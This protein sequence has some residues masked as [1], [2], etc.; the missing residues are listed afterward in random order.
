M[1]TLLVPTMVGWLAVNLACGRGSW[2]DELLGKIPAGIALGLGLTSATTFLG[3]LVLGRVTIVFELILLG[4]LLVAT[5]RFP[6]EPLAPPP[7]RRPTPRWMIAWVAAALVLV[8]SAG[9]AVWVSRAMHEPNGA[10]DAWDFWNMRGRWFV[11]AGEDWSRAFS[12]VALGSHPS[13]PPL[14]SASLARGFYLV[15]SETVAVPMLH[16]AVFTLAPPLVIGWTVLRVRGPLQACLA[17][18]TI[19]AAPYFVMHSADQYADAPLS[20]Y[21]VATFAFFALYDTERRSDARLAVLAGVAAS[22]A[23]L[24][25]NEGG[26]FMVTL[27]IARSV[28]ALRAGGRRRWIR[29][30]TRFAAGAV[31]LGVLLVIFKLGYSV[32]PRHGEFYVG[33]DESWNH[34]ALEHITIQVSTPD[35]WVGLVESWWFHLTHMDQWW[36]VPLLYLLLGYGVLAGRSPRRPRA[37]LDTMRLFFALQALIVSGLFVAWSTYDIREHMDALQRLLYQMLPSVLLAVFL[38]LRAPFERDPFDQDPFEKDR[39][40]P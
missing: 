14:L 16:A 8:V 38:T 34:G 11:R 19:L 13:Y 27:V 10:W 4:L 39:A 28:V 2:L 25:K 20:F 24:T 7:D 6:A 36:P 21:F 31:A 35:R 22:C 29:E 32:M 1:S 18:T 33:P 40:K 9:I 17:V 37:T 23:A 12:E 30:G 15:G 3:M 26:L 5:R